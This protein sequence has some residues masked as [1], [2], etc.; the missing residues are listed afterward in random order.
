MQA[1]D[2]YVSNKDVNLHENDYLLVPISYM[3]I[4]GQPGGQSYQYRP[5]T[6]DTSLLRRTQPTDIQLVV[7]AVGDSTLRIPARYSNGNERRIDCR[8]GLC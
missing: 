1:D 6:T 7:N 8:G 2:I 3:D 5:R 4:P